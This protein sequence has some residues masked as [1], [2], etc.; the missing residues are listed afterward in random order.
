MNQFAA[1]MKKTLGEGYL[2]P[3]ISHSPKQG[4]QDL[5]PYP[6]GVGC[7][8]SSGQSLHHSWWFY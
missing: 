3:L 5:A 8:V 2:S 1:D 6:H 7:R 4:M